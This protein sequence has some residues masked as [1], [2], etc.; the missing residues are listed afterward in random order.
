MLTFY[1][2]NRANCVSHRRMDENFF[3]LEGSVYLGSIIYGMRVCN[4]KVASS[5]DIEQ[6]A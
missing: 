5:S 1:F 3:F 4:V 6:T 2:R